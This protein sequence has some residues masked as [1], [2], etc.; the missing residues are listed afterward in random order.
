MSNN[1]LQVHERQT[2]RMRTRSEWFLTPTDA[3]QFGCAFSGCLDS[4]PTL[5]VL[6]GA[7]TC[8]SSNIGKLQICKRNLYTHLY[9]TIE[10]A[11]IWA[12]TNFFSG[13]CCSCKLE[14]PECLVTLANTS[15]RASQHP[16]C[17]SRCR[18]QCKCRICSET[19]KY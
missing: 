16:Y 14:L 1:N 7:N 15:V 8:S 11:P 18:T 12:T 6:R 13:A 2:E 4:D 3:A 10:N 19:S 9:Q 17:C 5:H